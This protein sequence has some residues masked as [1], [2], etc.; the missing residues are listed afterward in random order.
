MKAVPP[1]SVVM[2]ADL[3]NAPELNFYYCGNEC[4]IGRGM[5]IP[6]GE[7]GI[8]TIVARTIGALSGNAVEDLKSK[9]L[10]VL[11]DGKLTP[12][13]YPT[14]AWLLLNLDDLSKTFGELR[15]A[16]QKLLAEGGVNDKRGFGL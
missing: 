8:S 12:E 9:L 7:C 11:A 15:L 16:C 1:D 14:V 5:P 6:K 3:Y 4:P 2:M 13:N 10:Q